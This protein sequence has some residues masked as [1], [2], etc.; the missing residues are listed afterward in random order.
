MPYKLRFGGAFFFDSK[1]GC[2]IAT[3][4]SY[5]SVAT[6]KRTTW[7]GKMGAWVW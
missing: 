5:G 6:G 4:S 3:V 1:G 7:S 2:V